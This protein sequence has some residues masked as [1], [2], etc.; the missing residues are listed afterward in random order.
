M[1]EDP[2]STMLRAKLV[3][4]SPQGCDTL[5]ELGMLVRVTADYEKLDMETRR[6]GGKEG[7]RARLGKSGNIKRIHP[8]KPVVHWSVLRSGRRS[9]TPLT[10]Y[11]HHLWEL[12]FSIRRGQTCA[13]V[14]QRCINIIRCVAESFFSANSGITTDSLLHSG[15]FFLRAVHAPF[16]KTVCVAYKLL[17]F[18]SWTWDPQR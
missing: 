4:F 3:G 6:V 10:M 12:N 7:N 2:E 13:F 15:T 14:L 18:Q 17:D 8:A 9:R 5:V 16:R 1:G 11:M